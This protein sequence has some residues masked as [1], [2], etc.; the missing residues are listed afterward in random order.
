MNAIAKAVEQMRNEAMERAVA[1]MQNRVSAAKNEFIG[2]HW[3]DMRP[4]ANMSRAEYK[5]QDSLRNFVRS[6]AVM[7]ID[8]DGYYS[9]LDINSESSDWIYDDVA[10]C[11]SVSF[12][13]YVAKLES[14]VGE[15]D[16]AVLDGSLWHGS[17]LTVTKNDVVEKWKTQMIINVSSLGKLFNQF[18]TRKMK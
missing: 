17:V 9:V 14:K 2:K 13:A 18:P 11:A 3:D 6:I 12:D 7:G 10:K 4:T 16:T 1:L 15:C 5:Q 8:A